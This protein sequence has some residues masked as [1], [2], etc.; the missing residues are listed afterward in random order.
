MHYTAQ[1][2]FERQDVRQHNF[3]NSPRAIAEACLTYLL[4]QPFAEKYCLRKEELSLRLRE[5]PILRYSGQNWGSHARQGMAESV[6]DLAMEF[7]HQP[8]NVV[9]SRQAWDDQE[10]GY[11]LLWI[12]YPRARL[13]EAATAGL[14]DVVRTILDEGI[15]EA[16][17]KTDVYYWEATEALD[18][19]ASAGHADVIQLLLER[20]T[21]YFEGLD[22][23]PREGWKAPRY[24]WRALL[25]VINSGDISALQVL[26]SA[27]EDSEFTRDPLGRIRDAALYHSLGSC[28]YTASRWLLNNGANPDVIVSVHGKDALIYA[29]REGSNEMVSLLLAHGV[30]Y[31]YGVLL[32][33]ARSRNLLLG[34]ATNNDGGE[35]L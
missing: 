22:T 26:I 1:Q 27:E 34:S 10:Y 35:Y 5:Y 23:M 3:P 24:G 21:G 12:P 29:V 18:C 11:D 30:T 7:L 28:Q 19:A 31:D 13:V 17:W 9:S 20:L 32:G 4:F 25:G 16:W 33:A 8:I 15:D 6:R 2:Y 14:V